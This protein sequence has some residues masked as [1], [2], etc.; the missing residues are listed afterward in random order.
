LQIDL[1][2]ANA[3][4]NEGAQVTSDGVHHDAV[5]HVRCS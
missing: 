3:S 1:F 5:A 2:D 4:L